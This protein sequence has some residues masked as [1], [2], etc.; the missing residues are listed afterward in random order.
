MGLFPALSYLF[1]NNQARQHSNR[2]EISGEAFSSAQPVSSSRAALNGDLLN[3]RH[4][5]TTQCQ[6]RLSEME[7]VCFCS[8]SRLLPLDL[9]QQLVTEVAGG[10]RALFHE[11]QVKCLW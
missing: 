7:S 2:K 3:I 6:T 11:E 4:N 8:P 5:Q 10:N 1:N 9:A